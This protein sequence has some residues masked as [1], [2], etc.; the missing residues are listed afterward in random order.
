MAF[1]TGQTWYAGS[2]KW[3]A[4]AAWA[5][6]TSYTAGQLVRQLAA[7]A[8]GSE[9]VFACVVAGTSGGS[10]PSWVTTHGAKTT[11]NTVTW[12]DVTGK[13]AVNGDAANTSTW[14]SAKST[15]VS[16]GV[17]VKNV[18]GTHH[19]ICT[20]AG[21]AGTGSEPSWNTTA[22]ATTVDNAATWTSLGAVGAF[23]AWGAPAARLNLF[24]ATGFFSAAGDTV[25][26]SNS[27]AETQAAAL[28]YN[29][30]NSGSPARKTVVVCVDDS[31]APPAA[32]ATTGSVTTTGANAVSW[33][34]NTYTCGLVINSATGANATGMVLGGS[35]GNVFENCAFNKLSTSAANVT[36]GGGTGGDN[37]FRNC[38]FTFG[39]AGD[40][41]SLGL[42]RGRF[43]GGALADSGTTPTTLLTN[44]ST[45][46]YRFRG[47]DL[48]GV[49]GTLAALGTAP[50]DVYLESCRL[51]SGVTKQ[52]SG[53]NFPI[54]LRLY[55]HNCDSGATNT[56][57]Y[58]NAAAG[59]VQTETS[60]VRTG[61]ASN[62]T[63]PLSWLVTS[64]ANTSY[65]QPL[66]TS[67]IVQW[68]DTTGNSKTAAVELTTDTALTNAD[69]WLEIEHPGS[70]S[71]PLA[72]VVTTRAALLA[73]PVALTTS[74][75]TW[76][77]AAKT[78]KYKLSV[79]FTPQMK[80]PVKARV[81]VARASTTLYV[82]PL[83][84]IT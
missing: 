28:A 44:G 52:P 30:T 31:A 42:G 41:L 9:R 24:L 48:S 67:E 1:L 45:G 65:Y 35:T 26:V 76:G 3:S 25:F 20:T 74:A 10:E 5:A 59:I 62:G 2:T 47:V 37:E 8:V 68:Q 4:V 61:G 63:T 6:A 51:G 81:Y 77:G 34:Y 39:N 50:M 72:S 17:V 29:A 16:L 58:E 43:V 38:T 14:N 15:A 57:E 11:D 18:A 80:G 78:Y 82:E 7:P 19:F 84:V 40:L 21:N 13:A 23:S 75:A 71:H 70:A 54:N 79:A 53:S 60:V 55:L 12:Q 49:T 66:V 33:G 32:L 22:G 36:V 46:T 69:C 73:T 27:H 83:I 56:S 64:G